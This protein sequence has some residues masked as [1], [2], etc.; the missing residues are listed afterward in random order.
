MATIGNSTNLGLLIWSEI[1]SNLRFNCSG[2]TNEQIILQTLHVGVNILEQQYRAKNGINL[3]DMSPVYRSLPDPVR[4]NVRDTGGVIISTPQEGMGI[5]VVTYRYRLTTSSTWLFG[6]H[7]LLAGG[8]ANMVSQL[9]YV[10]NVYAYSSD[11][12]PATFYPGIR[13]LLSIIP[14]GRTMDGGQYGWIS[15]CQD[16]DPIGFQKVTYRVKY[17]DGTWG[18]FNKSFPPSLAANT[19]WNIPV[20]IKQVGLDPTNKT[21]DEIWVYVNGGADGDVNLLEYMIKVDN[22]PV[23]TWLDIHYRNSLGGWDFFRF[24][25]RVQFTT[26]AERKEYSANRSSKGVNNYFAANI[27]LKWSAATGYIS[28]QHMAA[29]NDL[30]VSKDVCIL[31]GNEWIPVKCTSKDLNWSDSKE[32]LFN[33]VF[34]FESAELYDVVPKQMMEFFKDYPEWR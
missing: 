24:R 10:P 16:L 5:T 28:Q 32:G 20:G 9:E 8:W 2:V 31:L 14:S 25:G 6:I 4:P 7:L 19:T 22:R 33:D 11:P 12:P 26:A 17:I 27:R 23:Y 18:V 3:I 13:R 15:Y 30:L 1:T 34:E 21:V 29:L